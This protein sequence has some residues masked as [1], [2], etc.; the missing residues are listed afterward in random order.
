M[1]MICLQA[2]HM[3]V[4]YLMGV[5]VGAYSL[6]IGREHTDFAEAK[7]Q[8][9]LVTGTLEDDAISSLACM[10]MAGAAAEAVHYPEVRS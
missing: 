10:A 1:H 6:D 7:L 3:L 8:K 5:P 2:A 4:G 9:R